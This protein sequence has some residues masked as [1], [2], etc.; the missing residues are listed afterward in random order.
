MR[1]RI[2][3]QQ[4][5]RRHLM[6]PWPCLLRFITAAPFHCGPPGLHLHVLDGLVCHEHDATVI[7]HKMI[8]VVRHYLPTTNDQAYLLLASSDG[9]NTGDDIAPCENDLTRLL[10]F[11]ATR[12]TN[13]AVCIQLRQSHRPS[14]RPSEG[15]A[16]SYKLP[17]CLL[18]SSADLES[19]FWR[20]ERHV[21]IRKCQ[22]CGSPTRF[23]TRMA[24]A[25]SPPHHSILGPAPGQ[26]KI[27]RRKYRVY[28]TNQIFITS[29]PQYALY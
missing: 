17:R 1:Q 16:P 11:S 7:Q 22:T 15:T 27:Y 8:F 12:Y 19:F 20:A 13:V 4:R 25:Y 3:T 14:T 28:L 29:P 26:K 21:R 24:I 5:C 2:S 9:N 10:V 6:M 18:E 23:A